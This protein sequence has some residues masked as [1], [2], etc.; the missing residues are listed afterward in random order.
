MPATGWQVHLDVKVPGVTKPGK[1]RLAWGNFGF[2]S[3]NHTSNQERDLFE[4][5]VAEYDVSLD[6]L[7]YDEIKHDCVAQNV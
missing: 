1:S 3:D 7:L 2:R 6:S 4:V 5:H